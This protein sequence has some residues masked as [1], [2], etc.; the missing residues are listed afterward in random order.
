MQFS[1]T[2]LMNFIIVN[3]EYEEHYD[4]PSQYETYE[5]PSISSQNAGYAELNRNSRRNSEDNGNYQR[6]QRRHLEYVIPAHGKRESYEDIE[7]TRNSPDYTELH[8]SK[9]ETEEC[10]RSTCQNLAKAEVKQL[11]A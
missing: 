2:I 4:T 10:Q 8:Q 7:I 5:E 1:L 9:R 11:L 6:L 3:T